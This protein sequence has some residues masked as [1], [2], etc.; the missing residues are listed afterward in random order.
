MTASDPLSLTLRRMTAAD[1]SAA[2]AL[3]VAGEQQQF[4]DPMP[5]TLDTTGLQRDNFVIETA[6]GIA[7]FFQID[8]RA[9]VYIAQPL[10]EL[11][12]VVI[13]RNQQGRG[14]GKRFIQKLPE[15]LQPE[16]PEASGVV[17]TVNCRNKLAYH[18]YQAG[19]F[20]DTGEIYAGGPSGPQH[21]M[22]MC[23]STGSE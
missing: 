5:L 18:V 8:T 20:H 1:H 6:A 19:G 16:Y 3:T 13:D 9:P 4:V 11:C 15:F 14:L 22:S 10:L 7:G 17:L 2:A 23:W 12:Q 21:I